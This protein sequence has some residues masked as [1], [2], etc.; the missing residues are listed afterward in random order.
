MNDMAIPGFVYLQS[1]D[2]ERN[3]VLGFGRSADGSLDSIGSYDTGGRGSGAPHLPSQGSVVLTADARWL[4]VTNAGSDDVSLFA[5][6]P[7]S[8]TLVDTIASGGTTPR[9]IAVRGSLVYVLNTAAPASVAGFRVESAGRL[10]PIE[11][12]SRPLSTPDP[13]PAQVAFSPDGRFLVVTERGTNSLGV[14]PVGKDGLLGDL[15]SAA[16][17]GATPY[18][19]D[20]SPQGALVVTEAFGGAV[21]AAAASSYRLGTDGASPVSRSVGSTRSEVCWAAVTP[22]GRYAYVTNFGDGTISSYAI[23]EAGGLELLEPVAA[24]TVEG[25]KGVRDEALSSN[26]DFLYA[27][28]ADAQQIFGWSVRKDGRLEAIGAVEVAPT[29]AAGLAVS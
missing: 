29:T 20:F 13:D 5:V 2:A 25:E 9:S 6:A 21:G 18:G 26:G 15:H 7:A 27:L 10:V 14:Y 4:L 22:D 19:F 16:S 1:N 12:S 8:L 24:S 28:D 11:G 3:Q 17:S 23:G